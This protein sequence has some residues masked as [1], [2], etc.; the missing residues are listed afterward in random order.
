MNR[1]RA[2]FYVFMYAS[3]IKNAVDAIRAAEEEIT[4]NSETALLV[5][6]DRTRAAERAAEAAFDKICNAW[7]A[8]LLKDAKAERRALS[9]LQHESALYFLQRAANIL[10]TRSTASA[11]DFVRSIWTLGTTEADKKR[12]ECFESAEKSR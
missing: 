10:L 6:Q 1:E 9:A 11:L 12:L 7:T 4:I 5:L 8:E 2:S 3:A